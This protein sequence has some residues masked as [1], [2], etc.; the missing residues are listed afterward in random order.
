MIGK[1]FGTGLILAVGLVAG[2]ALAE[3]SRHGGGHGAIQVWGVEIDELEYRYSD[4][5]EELGIWD[6]DIFYGTDDL[7]FIWITAGE[8]DIEEQ[9][10]EG[11]ENQL[12]GQVPISEF[13]D[14]RAGVRF[15]TPEG[16]DRTY[17]VLGVVGLAP[18][19]VE[20]EANLYVSEEGNTSAGLEAEYELLLTNYWIL[21][22]TVE[23]TVAFDEDRE[24][25]VGKGLVGT[26]TG[27]RL[28]YDL[29]DRSLSPYVG[30]VHERSYGDTAD[31]AGAEGGSTED[32]FAVIGARITF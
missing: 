17:A 9:A 30:V 13:F 10:Y 26:E 28:S 6:A 18:Q 23:A 31:L 3:Q 5:D 21:A 32:W 29:I 27:L 7:K 2:Q 12:L 8:Y 22:A 24:I 15:D 16:P 4:N 11:L 14:A 1:T 25:G 20:V 19:W